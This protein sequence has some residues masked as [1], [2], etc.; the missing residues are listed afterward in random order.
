MGFKP[1]TITGGVKKESGEFKP[2]AVQEMESDIGKKA[3]AFA[4]GAGTGAVGGLG[5]L[6]KFGAYTVPEV[7]G[8]REQDQ[9]D[10]FMGRQTLF[11]TIEK[12]REWAG[13]AGIQRPEEQYRGYETGGEFVGGM[14]TG[15]PGLVKGSTRTFLGIPTKSGEKLAQ[16]A[17]ALGFKLSPAQ[18]RQDV[19]VSS[20]GA[21]GYAKE[22]QTLA[23]KLA[24]KG[25]GEQIDEITPEFI[26]RRLETLGEEYN[27]LYK[28]KFFV[29]DSDVENVLNNILAKE[30]ELGY[31]GVTP[32]KQ[33]TQTI[34]ENLQ[35]TSKIAGE[36]LQRLRNVLTQRARSTSSRSDAHEIYNLVDILDQSVQKNNPAI[37]S[38]LE[39]LRPQ[40]R[41]SIILEDLYRKGGIRN[42]NISLEQLGN[43][44]GG[45]R[46]AVRRT[47]SDIDTLGE[48]GREL[49]IRGR[50]E[51][52]GTK[53]STGEDILKKALGTTLGGL[54]S[55]TG[56]R[57][58]T[59][60]KAQKALS[61]YADKP[62]T[63]KQRAGSTA[64]V[65]SSGG[66]LL[67]PNE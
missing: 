46:D 36:D 48:Y 1:D 26:G 50:F 65:G 60:R 27:K 57:S 62:L 45:K 54:A 9:K 22:N 7:L 44:L 58:A 34:L 24:S 31:A 39:K 47:A 23:N 63:V 29:V 5:E 51:Q 14:I 53:G 21:T 16:E 61:R 4:Y 11:P 52:T 41:N 2:D 67:E 25:T 38:A 18:V 13:K 55:L 17:E 10:Q 12:A 56:L 8:F 40:Y 43:M 3:G 20:K 33:A 28:G 6:E 66:A 30:V 19:P 37:A 42:G 15:G 32:V 35:S 59:A 64:G 49:G